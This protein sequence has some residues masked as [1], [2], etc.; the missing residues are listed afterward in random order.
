VIPEIRHRVD[1]LGESIRFC[2]F[3]PLVPFLFPIFSIGTMTDQLRGNL[4]RS[5]PAEFPEELH[6]TL[7]TGKHFRID[8]IVSAGHA[9]E[10]DFWYD[11]KEAEWILVLQG[12][13]KLQFDDSP[14]LVHLKSG[15]WMNIPP[16]RRH[17]VDWTSSDP[18]T[19]WLAIYY[20]A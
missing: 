18:L 17:R 11:Q 9:S 1:D 15:D 8:R 14:E 2:Y 7:A 12:E 13:A 5:L 10:V 3:Q 4:L 20:Q 19:V 16:R 6:E